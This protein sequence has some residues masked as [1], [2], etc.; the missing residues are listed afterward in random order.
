[1]NNYLIFFISFALLNVVIK[2]WLNL[3]NKN[4]ILQHRDQV[5][6]EFLNKTPLDTHQKSVDYSVSKINFSNIVI[7]YHFALLIVWIPLAGLGYIDDFIRS[8]NFSETVTGL[9]FLALYSVI[10]GLLTL[11][12]SIYQTFV[13][14][15]KFGFNKTTPKLFCLDLVKQLLLSAAIMA[16]ILYLLF[17]IMQKLGGLWWV[18]AW[19]LIIGVQFVML[20][21]YPKFIAP[22]F[23]KFTK[24][25]NA[26][27]QAKIERLSSKIH[28]HFSDYYVMNASI[29]SSHGNAYF[30]GIGKNKRIVFFDTLLKT[31][32]DNEV[33]AVLAHELGHLKHKHI[34]KSMVMS[35]LFTFIGMAI[36]GYLYSSSEFYILH[37]AK[38]SSYM[39]L[40]LFSFI[41]PVY[42]FI[43]TPI[44]S[45]MSRKNEYQ[46]DK[47]A[48][49]FS[50]GKALIDALVK[51]YNDNASC[52][53]PSPLYSKFYYSHPPALERV[54]YIKSCL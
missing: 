23:N 22:L 29:R 1:M 34:L 27:L 25:D 43:L 46:A 11:P 36:L 52:L 53:T 32:N 30:T 37:Q 38:Q 20:W 47:F 9:C 5:P 39:A 31:L 2:I 42:T 54:A 8:F 6:E 26:N 40:I 44:Q 21:A 24:L 7:I 16:P 19:A 13:L 17:E 50:D 10:S 3:V 41:T 33:E 14:E 28:I 12:E 35:I 15:E 49:D 18:Y 48:C 45:W 51:M 4:Y